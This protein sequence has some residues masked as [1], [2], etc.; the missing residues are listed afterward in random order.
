MPIPVEWGHTLS[1][2]PDFAAGCHAHCYVQ[3][4]RWGLEGRD[5]YRKGIVAEQGLHTSERGHEVVGTDRRYEP[6]HSLCR[7]LHRVVLTCPKMIAPM[8]NGNPYTVFTCLLD[9]VIDEQLGYNLIHGIVPIDDDGR[10]GVPD[11]LRCA[12][13]VSGAGQQT[14]HICARNYANP[15]ATV[16]P[17]TIAHYRDRAEGGVGWID[18]EATFV[19][20]AG[21]GRTHQLRLHEDRCIDGFRAL[22]E[23]VHA[24]GANLRVELHHTGGGTSSSIAGLQP[25]GPSLVPCLES[26][27]D[28]P[29]ELSVEEIHQVVR[30]YAEASVRAVEAGLDPVD[31]HSA[32]GYLPLAFPS[33]FWNRRR[34]KYG[35]SFANRTRFALRV[36]AAIKAAIPSGVSLAFASRPRRTSTAASGWRMASGLHKRSSEV[37][38]TVAHEHWNIRD[39]HAH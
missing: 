12:K 7:Y 22:A 21:R 38:S 13:R 14:P 10:A 36:I 23:A 28:V 32:H 34:D 25:V 31:L 2:Q 24:S 29:R 33:P 35:G 5:S 6:N 4:E 39:I 17:R 15:D 18:V 9:G 27:D 30:R 16:S 3:H 8:H 26:G 1:C 37:G 20:P 19:D 11:H